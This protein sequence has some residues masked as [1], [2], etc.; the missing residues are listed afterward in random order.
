MSAGV[1]DAVVTIAA[2]RHG[3]GRCCVGGGT[4]PASVV[5][6]RHIQ[7]PNAKEISRLRVACR[8]RAQ[9][10][11]SRTIVISG[12]DL[13]ELRVL[14]SER[15][16]SVFRLGPMQAVVLGHGDLCAPIPVDVTEID[17]VVAARRNRW[18]TAGADALGV[19]YGPHDPGQT[20]VGGDGHSWPPNTVRVHALFV[21]NISCAVRRN[22]YMSVQTAASSRRH[23]TVY[24]VDRRKEVDRHTRPES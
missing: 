13:G 14:D 3:G 15:R 16:A 12:D 19:G 5:S 20:V 7:M 23:R 24:A 11:I 1:T 8:G 9:K 2:A 17:R 4:C 18:V 6:E 21:G 10:C 22:A